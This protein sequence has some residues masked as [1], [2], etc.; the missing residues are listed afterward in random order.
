MEI[1]NLQSFEKDWEQLSVPEQLVSD[2]NETSAITEPGCEE[3]PNMHV[4]IGIAPNEL[5]EFDNNL[6][7]VNKFPR[8]GIGE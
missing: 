6:A 8:E 5:I 4:G 1:E 7:G 2:E 3:D